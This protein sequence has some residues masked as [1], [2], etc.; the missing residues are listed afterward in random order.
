MARQGKKNTLPPFV[1]MTWEMLNSKAY[2]QL[3]PSSAKI[4]PYF[5]GKIQKVEYKNPQ[6]YK[7]TFTFTG[8]EAKSLGF[9]KSTFSN[10]I[11]ALMLYGFIE[12]IKKGGLRGCG[13][14]AS[15]FTLSERWKAFG[16]QNF[17]EVK[18]ECFSNKV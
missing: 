4:L 13:H 8:G 15:L 11:K 10:A 2:K 17:R 1:P 12:P 5:I 14:T 16:S 3:P 7:I 18:W 9:G 6:R